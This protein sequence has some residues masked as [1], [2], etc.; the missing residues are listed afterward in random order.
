MLH[1]TKQLL[2]R[3]LN[4]FRHDFYSPNS[5]YY[6]FD[7]LT[8]QDAATYLETATSAPAQALTVEETLDALSSLAT[9]KGHTGPCRRTQGASPIP[10]RP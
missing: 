3:F 5:D 1:K 4:L 2:K 9:S 7:E 10:L 8:T 6:F